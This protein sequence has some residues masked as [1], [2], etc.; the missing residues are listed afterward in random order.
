MAPTVLVTG[1]STGI[2]RA[3]AE[4]LADRGWR[5]L[6]GARSDAALAALDAIAGMEAIRLDVTKPEQVEAAAAATG[7]HLDA[8]V[9]NAGVAV[10]GPVEVLALEEW[11]SQ[12][13]INL[14]GQVAVTRAVLSAV[15]AARGRIVNVSSIGGR[16]ALPL[17]GPY[18]AS[19][20]ALEAMTDSLRRELRGQGVA[21][22]AVEPGAVATPIWGKG[23]EGGDAVTARMDTAQQQRYG[24]LVAAVRRAAERSGRE[25]VAPTRVADAVEAALTASRPRTRYVVGREARVQATLGRLLPDR[26]MDGLV[27]RA[28]R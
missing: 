14:L 2:G 22:V 24:R 6:A 10:T 15:L 16:V 13:E 27:A 20:F 7:P 23:V 26:V 5:V 18:A 9:N 12:L 1:A 25:G 17:F 8:L 4:R 3:C 19:K 11:R 28:L 21:V